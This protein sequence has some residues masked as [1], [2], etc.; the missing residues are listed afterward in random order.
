MT[1]IAP[2][3]SKPTASASTFAEAG[4]GALVLLQRGFAK[5][6]GRRRSP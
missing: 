5:P 6:T 1:K 4:S 2:G 3:S